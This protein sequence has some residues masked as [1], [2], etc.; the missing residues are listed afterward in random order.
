MQEPECYENFPVQTLV[1]SNGL[2]LLIYGAGAFIL[3]QISILYVIG[4]IFVIFL[5]EYRLVAS[6][7]VHCYY[8]GKRCAFGKGLICASFFQKGRPEEF[9]RKQITW[10]EIAP[11]FLV[12][13]VPA[14]AGM[15]LLVQEFSLI[16]LL[17]IITL[18]LLGF[19]GNAVVRG[20]LAC[21]FCKQREKGC[22]AEQLFDRSIPEER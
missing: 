10:K 16:I 15:Y 18:F 19:A 17:L 13:L 2:S 9:N 12:F 3:S 8:F 20:R 4:Y 7:C 1:I 6:H 11:D 21:R 22:P 5:L 14:L